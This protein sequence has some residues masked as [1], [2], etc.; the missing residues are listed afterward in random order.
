VLPTFA[1]PTTFGLAVWP[2]VPAATFFAAD[3]LVTVVYPARV[4]CVVTVTFL[5]RSAARGV[6]VDFVAPLTAFPS[7]FHW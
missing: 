1:V 3:V 5:P 2:S 4:A 6:N 7:T